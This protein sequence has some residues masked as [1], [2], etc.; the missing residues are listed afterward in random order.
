[1]GAG[2]IRFT[3]TTSTTGWVAVGFGLGLRAHV[4][5]DMYFGW[6][7]GDGQPHV[8]DSWSAVLGPPPR[9]DTTNDATDIEGSE[10]DGTTVISFTRKITST[11]ATEDVDLSGGLVTLQWGYHT[12]SDDP[13]VIHTHRGFANVNLFGANPEPP[14]ITDAGH[15]LFVTVLIIAGVHI[16][17]R[18]T[19]KL[20]RFASRL[21]REVAASMPLPPPA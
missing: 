3:I 20:I 11:D 1:M 7:D 8:Q 4:N 18:H 16:L 6:V 10:I 21:Q 14:W 12:S 5:S 15:G 19:K 17:Q 13:S 9:A 2:T